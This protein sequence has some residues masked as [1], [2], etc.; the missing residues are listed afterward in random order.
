LKEFIKWAGR[1]L[2]GA[3]AVFSGYALWWLGIPSPVVH[4]LNAKLQNAAG[5]EL[6]VLVQIQKNEVQKIINRQ[7][8]TSAAI[9]QCKLEQGPYSAALS[10]NGVNIADFNATK[11][12]IE[13]SDGNTI[14]LTAKIRNVILNEYSEPC[15]RLDG[16]QMIGI[17]D[18]L[19]SNEV[20]I[21]RWPKRVQGE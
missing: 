2:I 18:R 7:Y 14:S 3:M 6:V 10:Y 15:L 16:G 1:V 11:A 8:Y 21:G 13:K 19:T 9:Y 4:I 12:E 17:G 5:E 20:R